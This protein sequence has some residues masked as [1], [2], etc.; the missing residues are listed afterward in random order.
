MIIPIFLVSDTYFIKIFSARHLDPRVRAE[1]S[2][3]DI[4]ES[5]PYLDISQP[6][7]GI[8]ET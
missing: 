8:R 4:D 6:D 2:F 3:S 5:L 1:K 7:F